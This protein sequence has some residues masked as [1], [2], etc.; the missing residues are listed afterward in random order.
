MAAEV[1][2]EEREVPLSFPGA[3][4]LIG[5]GYTLLETGAALA[6]VSSA[7][8]GGGSVRARRF[9][10]VEAGRGARGEPLAYIEQRAAALGVVQPFVGML[11]HGST[12]GTGVVEG[13]QGGVAVLAV[14]LPG[15]ERGRPALIVLVDAQLLPGALMDALV[16]AAEGRAEAMAPYDASASAVS[17]SLAVGVTMRGKLQPYAEKTSPLPALIRSRAREAIAGLLAAEVPAGPEAE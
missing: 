12:E 13:E 6:V 7:P 9:L 5:R 3:R 1:T 16:A 10:C 2:A 17:S 4:L 14:A 11:A 8:Y 15:A